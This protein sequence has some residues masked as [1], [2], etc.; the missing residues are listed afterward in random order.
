M[1]GKASEL[2]FDFIT[3]IL[4]VKTLKYHG[5]IHLFMCYLHIYVI[6]KNVLIVINY[7][8]NIIC[9][10]GYLKKGKEMIPAS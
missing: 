10:S 9:I 8:L 1:E 6:C 5:T 3:M 7:T 4:L 2:A